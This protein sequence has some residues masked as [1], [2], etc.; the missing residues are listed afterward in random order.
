MK[1]S[2]QQGVELPGFEIYMTPDG[3]AL[4]KDR[5][6]LAETLNETFRLEVINPSGPSPNEFVGCGAVGRVSAVPGESDLCVKISTPQIAIDDRGPEDLI[7]QTRFLDLLRSSLLPS[8]TT[9]GIYV[10]KQYIAARNTEQIN[11]S[12]QERLSPQAIPLCRLLNANADGKLRKEEGKIALRRVKNAVAGSALT[13]CLDDLH[14]WYFG[15]NGGNILV[16][17]RNGEGIDSARLW[18]IDQPAKRFKIA[19]A[20]LALYRS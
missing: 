19:R 3:K 20:I 18:I 2:F 7:V 8:G 5:P 4:L 9:H 11:L 15:L 10:P 6:D 16:D 1:V 14:H 12:L 13:L 17:S